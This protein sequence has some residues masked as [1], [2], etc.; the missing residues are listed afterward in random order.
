MTTPARLH[1]DRED[2]ISNL[3]A[4]AGPWD[5]AQAIRYAYGH[6]LAQSPG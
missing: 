4:K 5:R 3:F 1:G 6:G 2:H